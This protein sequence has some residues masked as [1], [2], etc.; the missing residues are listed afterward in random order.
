MADSVYLDHAAAPPAPATPLAAF[1]SSLQS[2]LLSNPH[3]A[4]TAG[5]QTA[6][7][8]DRTR[9]RVLQD[10]FNIPDDRLAEWDVVFT[11]GGATQGIKTIGDSWDWGAES[12]ETAALQYLVESHTRCGSFLR[13]TLCRGETDQYAS[14]SLVGLRGYP[15]ARGRTVKAHRTPSDLLQSA[16][17][18]RPSSPPTLYAYPAQCNATGA[19]LGLRYSAQI[20]RADPN[21][22]ILVDAAAYSSTSIL[23]LGAVPTEEAPD[24]VV[25]SIYKIF[26]R[27]RPSDRIS[28]R[29]QRACALPPNVVRDVN[30]AC[31]CFRA[32][33]PLSESC[34]SVEHR[35]TC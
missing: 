27:S 32:S 35:R 2:Q 29:V 33:R 4:S 7:V 9:T 18:S 11:H 21:A 34:S 10:L 15:L 28:F 12:E 8:I 17:Q 6:L 20:K 16:A 22:K 3:S 30:N 5:V 13:R 23:D 14:A 26:V 25:A 19:R 31:P 24:F 1:A